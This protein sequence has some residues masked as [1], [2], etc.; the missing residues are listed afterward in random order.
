M[1]ATAFHEIR[2]M[3]ENTRDFKMKRQNKAKRTPNWCTP[4]TLKY[5]YYQK[6]N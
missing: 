3:P 2:Y 6:Q 5:K 1:N 4:M